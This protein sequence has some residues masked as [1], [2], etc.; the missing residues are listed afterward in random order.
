MFFV[1]PSADGDDG[2]AATKLEHGG[3]FD[4]DAFVV[5][6]DTSLRVSS[7]IGLFALLDRML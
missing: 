3:G 2:E 5:G 4:V 7:K 6:V 1:P